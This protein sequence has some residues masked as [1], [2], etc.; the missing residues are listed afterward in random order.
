M[1]KK[2]LAGA[3]ALGLMSSA[4]LAQTYIPTSPGD[5]PVP[6]TATTTTPSL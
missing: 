3:A 4:A 1:I 5:R 2:L 6:P